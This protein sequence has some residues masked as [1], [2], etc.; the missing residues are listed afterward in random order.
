MTR[1]IRD[2]KVPDQ[3]TASAWFQTAIRLVDDLELHDTVTATHT[4][5]VILYTRALAEDAGLDRDIVEL[6]SI[7]AAL[8]DV[9]KLD[10][11]GGILRKPG[12]L[13]DQEFDTVRAHTTLGEARVL[14]AGITDP[15]IRQMVRSHHE[16]LDAS[17]YPDNLAGENIPRPALYFGVID[18]Y[19]AMTSRRPYST[20]LREDAEDRAI[21]ELLSL[22]GE[23]YCPDA[24]ERFARM[25][26]RG[27]L[28][29]IARHFNEDSPRYQMELP[30]SDSSRG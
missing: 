4:W 27:D 1:P 26:E 5:R 11:D 8:H 18:S 15:L 25:H 7:G 9:G 28:D 22:R 3:L 16:R 12:R 19:D 17:G 20:D 14:D 30:G 6:L 23:K 21:E 13:T 10:I 24:V 2:S 29:W